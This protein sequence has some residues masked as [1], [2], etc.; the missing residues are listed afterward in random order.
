MKEDIWRGR[1]FLQY[2]EPL[3][4]SAIRPSVKLAMATHSQVQI[5]ATARSS[6]I[7]ITF[8]DASQAFL[9]ASVLETRVF[10]EVLR[11]LVI[12]TIVEE[13]RFAIVVFSAIA[14]SRASSVSVCL[15][16][17]SC[18]QCLAVAIS[19]CSCLPALLIILDSSGLAFAFVFERG[20]LQW[21][22][23]RAG[24][25]LPAGRRHHR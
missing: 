21:S 11:V 23:D 24:A 16:G 12:A 5:S 10:Y 13:G 3:E 2:M 4:V 1:I 6:I 22:T 8:Q 19:E 17:K 15:I 7:I 9:V 14:G 25:I 20:G 18:S